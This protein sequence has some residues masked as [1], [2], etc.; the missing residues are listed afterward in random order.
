MTEEVQSD[1]DPFMT[2]IIATLLADPYRQAVILA[3]ELPSWDWIINNFRTHCL[4]ETFLGGPLE[5]QQSVIITGDVEPASSLHTS[6]LEN[7][8]H[9]EDFSEYFS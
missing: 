6:D 1:F 7:S 8:D 3:C 5:N 2:A 4:H 9:L